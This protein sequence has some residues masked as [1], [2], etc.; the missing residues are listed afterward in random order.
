MIWSHLTF[1]MKNLLIRT[2]TEGAHDPRQRASISE[3]RI[4]L[5]KYAYA[6]GRGAELALRP[7]AAK[8]REYQG[9]RA[10]VRRRDGSG[11]RSLKI[12]RPA[13]L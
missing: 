5:E 4:A 13:S 7:R 8:S 3:W 9:R 1:E 10:D 12:G 11:I 6:L 2:L